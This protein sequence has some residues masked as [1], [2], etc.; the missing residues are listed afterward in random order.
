MGVNPKHV[1][2]H[3]HRGSRGTHPENTLPAFQEALAAGADILELDMQLSADQ[4]LIVSH[5]P[6]LDNHLCKDKNGKPVDPPIA[7]HLLKASEIAEYD[8]GST[9]NPR[10]PEQQQIKNT[11]KPTLEQLFRWAKEAAP[12]IQFNIETKMVA[13]KKEWIADPEIFVTKTLE[14]LRK[15]H[16]IDRTILQSFDPRTLEVA[17]KKA[18]ELRLSY[19]FEDEKDFPAR[20]ARLGAKIASPEA[21]LVTQETV[22]ECHQNG[23][24]VHPWTINEPK[25][26]ERLIQAG[27]DG[28]ITD[29]PRKLVAYLARRK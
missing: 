16:L 11:P 13:P 5:D 17:K 1:L 2:I 9:P 24:E 10:F 23:I 15:Y 4:V 8:C 28:I 22:K 3:G 12:H 20:T 21:S 27:V 18:P 26:W 25:E 29:Y 14:L 6:V 7:I 19:L